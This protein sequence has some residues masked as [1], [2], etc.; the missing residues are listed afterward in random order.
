MRAYPTR[1]RTGRTPTIEAFEPVGGLGYPL[2]DPDPSKPIPTIEEAFA[3]IED[4]RPPFAKYCYPF[5]GVVKMKNRWSRTRLERVIAT[6]REGICQYDFA[7]MFKVPSVYEIG[8]WVLNTGIQ[9][10][11]GYGIRTDAIGWLWLVESEEQDRWWDD[12][13]AWIDAKNSAHYPRS[14]SR[15]RRKMRT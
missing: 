13:Q 9:N 6:L 4:T 7:T 1:S 2:F 8:R 11:R 3:N 12:W 10:R 5:K 15:K 14:A